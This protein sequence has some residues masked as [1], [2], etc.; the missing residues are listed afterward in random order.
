MV[1]QII[2]LGCQIKHCGVFYHIINAKAVLQSCHAPPIKI[3][4]QNRII[5]LF[6]FKV[7]NRIIYLSVFQVPNIK[8]II[9]LNE[10][11]HVA[12]PRGESYLLDPPTS[13]RHRPVCRYR[14][15]DLKY[16]RYIHRVIILQIIIFSLIGRLHVA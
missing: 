9:V 5:Y 3:M 16:C 10:E 13:S 2:K 12:P 7:P 14:K 15:I 8:A 11:L 4:L 6:V 1:K